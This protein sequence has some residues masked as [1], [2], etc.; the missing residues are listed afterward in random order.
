MG[1][2]FRPLML[3]DHDAIR[4]DGIMIGARG[5]T[6]PSHC[7]GTSPLRSAVGSSRATRSCTP[8]RSPS[9]RGTP[10]GLATVFRGAL[11]WRLASGAPRADASRLAV[12]AALLHSGS[13]LCRVD[14]A[15]RLAGQMTIES[16]EPP[17]WRVVSSPGWE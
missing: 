7:S 10:S 16:D 3:R 11:I 14:D 8:R 2:E 5:L 17:G 4:L 15:A 12:A 9:C 13:E 6:T 1:T